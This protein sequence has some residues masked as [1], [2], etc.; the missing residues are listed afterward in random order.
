MQSECG[1]VIASFVL[2][3]VIIRDCKV[4]YRAMPTFDLAQ[5]AKKIAQPIAYERKIT[6]FVRSVWCI[7]S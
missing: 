2:G 7:E 5:L 4:E 1:N 3:H 6:T